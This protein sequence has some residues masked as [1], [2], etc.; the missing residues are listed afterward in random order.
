MF[1]DAS[2]KRHC[3]GKPLRQKRGLPMNPH[4]SC[5]DPARLGEL[6]RDDLPADEHARLTEHVDACDN[7][8]QALDKLTSAGA[9]LPFPTS[10][11]S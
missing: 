7:C 8:Q 3:S 11:R 9:S 10:S 1:S 5:P 2:E 6:L 4:T